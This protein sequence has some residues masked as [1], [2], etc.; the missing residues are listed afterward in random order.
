MSGAGCAVLR[1]HDDARICAKEICFGAVCDRGVCDINNMGCAMAPAAADTLV[2]YFRDT[3]TKATDYGAIVTGDLGNVGSPVFLE[4]C[5]QEG[6]D[7]GNHLDCG[8]MIFASEAQGVFAGGSGCG[9]SA[10]VLC[11]YFLPL[12]ERGEMGDIL[13]M[14]TGALM[15]TTSFQQG[16]SIPGI[17]HLVH[18]APPRAK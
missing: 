7:I 2:A 5:A 17:A 6:Y 11:A 3:G 16:E 9:C 13:F 10:S 1:P 8:K 18:L 15:S 12:M 14:A 4:L